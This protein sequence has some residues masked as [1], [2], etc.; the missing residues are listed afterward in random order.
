MKDRG[1]RFFIC[2]RAGDDTELGVDIA[3]WDKGL[4]NLCD[5]V[6]SVSTCQLPPADY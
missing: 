3:R 5:Q 4:R 6:A 1:R 2:K